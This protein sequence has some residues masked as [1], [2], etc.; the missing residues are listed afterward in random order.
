MSLLE[1]LCE[2]IH[3]DTETNVQNISTNIDI[4]DLH[5]TLFHCYMLRKVDDGIGELAHDIA[6]KTYSL[7]KHMEDF[8]GIK[9]G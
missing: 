8:K 7:L 9:A 6:I 3:R 1:I 2:E 4:I 5:E